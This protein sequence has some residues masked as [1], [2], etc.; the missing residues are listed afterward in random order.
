MVERLVQGN[1]HGDLHDVDMIAKPDYMKILS[2]PESFHRVGRI[3]QAGVAVKYA[4][5]DVPN[6]FREFREQ[7]NLFPDRSSGAGVRNVLHSYLEAVG[8]A[9][10]V[11]AN[12]LVSA[13]LTAERAQEGG[14]PM[15]QGQLLRLVLSEMGPAGAKLLQAIHSNPAT[16]EDI[17]VD[18][19]NSK[20]DHNPPSRPEVIDLVRNAGLLD[21]SHPDYVTHVGPRIGSGSFGIT[22]AN[23]TANGQVA[24]TFLRRERGERRGA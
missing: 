11:E 21:P 24:D 16:P 13:L 10:P 12:L 4:I 18:L 2:D 1:G 7:Y 5:R 3:R 19:G 17:R 14:K 22:V 8:A 6:Q 9:N 23:E 20:S 15:R